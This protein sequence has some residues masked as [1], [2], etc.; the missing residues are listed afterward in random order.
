MK[1]PNGYGSIFKLSGKRRKPYCVR[2]ACKYTFDSEKAVE[3]RPVLGYY[4]TKA[5]AMQALAEYNKSPYDLTAKTTFAE[6]YALWYAEKCKKSGDKTQT[7]YRVAFDKCADI[8]DKAVSDLR[9]QDY[10]AILDRYASQSAASVHN[11]LTVIRSV[12]RYAYQNEIIA[13]DYAQYL[14]GQHAEKEIIRKVYTDTEIQALWDMPPDIVRDVTLILLY[15][16][17][18][19]NELLTMTA[20]NID[21]ENMLFHGGMKTKA[22]KNR[23]VP[24]HPRI[25]PIV[26]HYASGFDIKYLRFYRAVIAAG[27]TPHDT[28]HTFVSR[29]QSLGADH[30]CIERLVGHASKGITDAV[31]THKDID[32]LRQ[33]ISLLS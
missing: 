32:E 18:R 14:Q 5:E 22:G 17:F 19:V 3:H 6:I 21:L 33:T 16:G 15:S 11:I 28:R 25:Q 24:I 29:L 2:I 27:H 1:N 20:E 31:Y 10:Q 23:I 12:S 13:K 26:K 7:A 9:L 4:R 8:H 30:I